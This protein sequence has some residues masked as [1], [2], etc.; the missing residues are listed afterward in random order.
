[1]VIIEL[2]EQ[3]NYK[4]QL[5]VGLIQVCDMML[6]SYARICILDNVI[7]MQKGGLGFKS[8]SIAFYLHIFMIQK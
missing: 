1:M 2:Y 3:L 6:L 7:K 8:M 5:L 4:I